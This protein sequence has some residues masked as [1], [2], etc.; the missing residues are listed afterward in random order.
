[1]VTNYFN[2]HTIGLAESFHEILGARF[3]AL[4]TKAVDDYRK[5]IGWSN[6]NIPYIQPYSKHLEDVLSCDVLLF[7][8]GLV[9]PTVSK[10]IK[11]NG[12]TFL[13][14][15]R[16]YKIPTT[17]KTFL[18][19]KV[20]AYLRFQRYR[21]DCFYLLSMGGYVKDDMKVINAF[22]NDHILKW[23]YFPKL[24]NESA[25]RSF[26]QPLR[27]IWSGRMLTW[28][29]PQTAID[30]FCYIRQQGIE[31]ELY[32]YGDGEIKHSLVIPSQYSDSIHIYGFI[33]AAQMQHQYDRSDI[34]LVTSDRYEG[35][36]AVVNEGMGHGCVVIAD[37]MVGSA[38]TLI[39]NGGNGLIYRNKNDWLQLAVYLK[40]PDKLSALALKAKE[41]IETT[42]NAHIAAKRLIRFAQSVLKGERDFFYENGP[43]SF[44]E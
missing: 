3:L 18:K 24:A 23:G 21:S 42:W 7:S 12:L 38:K 10:R 35:W 5:K 9:D 26:E 17:F 22:D 2:P 19:R 6:H 4:E 37:A 25:T 11:S 16:P 36:G 31:G 1:M 8:G 29:H 44:D 33:D 34:V 32:M 41:T 27:F 20:G 13:A 43:V 28:K 30:L 14:I 39:Q 15:E 40:S